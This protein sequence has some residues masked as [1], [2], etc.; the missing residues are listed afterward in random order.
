MRKMMKSL[1]LVAMFMA[2]VSFGFSVVS[3]LS[4]R[5][6]ISYPLAD[7]N[8]EGQYKPMFGVSYEVWY[9]N[10]LSLGISPYITELQA[11]EHGAKFES[12]IAGGDL[13]LKFR[14]YWK[15]TNIVIKDGAINRIAPFITAGAGLVYFFPKDGNGNHFGYPDNDYSHTSLVIPSLGAGLTFSTKSDVS[16]DLGFQRQSV[17][18]DYLEG[19]KWNKGKDAFWMAYLGLG[20]NFGVIHKVKPAPKYVFS[21][22]EPLILTGVQFEFNKADLTPEAKPILDG[23]AESL[24]DYPTVELEIDGHTDS[25][26]TLEYNNDLSLKRAQTVKDYLVSK[27]VKENRLTV[28]GFGPSRPIASN[29]TPEGQAKNRRIEFVRTK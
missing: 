9:K 6:G 8:G 14:P 26:G 22:T 10:M 5:G 18:S 4:L 27:G 28:A 17:N 13:A 20:Y 21:M 25:I 7:I 12:D 15:G 3:T 16:I 23:V 11:S 19:V 2:I 1:L 29:D 24:Q